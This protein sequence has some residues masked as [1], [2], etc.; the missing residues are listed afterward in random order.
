M[1]RKEFKRG[2][3][4]VI[5]GARS[6]KSRFAL[7]VCN[8]LG[9]E[10]IFLA[11]GQALDREMA[12]RIRRHREERGDEWMTV[13]EPIKLA[14]SIR[15]LD[16]EGRVILIDCLTLWL[17]NLFLEYHEDQE[18]IVRALSDLERQLR[19][20]QG[21]VVVVSNEVG[22]GIVPDNALSRRFRDTAG[23]ANQ[24]IAGIARKVVAIIAGT[25]LV[26]KDE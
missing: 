16:A 15:D 17:N 20:A 6:G 25:P 1:F 21:A 7:D 12:E 14:E 9:K 5:G 10:R 4:L 11:T 2:C 26:L 18:A 24:R 13:E 19:T 8:G 22:M 23:S 3:M